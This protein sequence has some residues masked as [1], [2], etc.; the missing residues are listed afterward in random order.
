MTTGIHHI[1]AIAGDPQANVDFYA[2][3]LGLRVIKRT[4][5][6]DDPGTWHLY[7]G[8]EAGRPGTVLTFFPWGSRAAKGRPGSGQSTAV[9]FS[10]PPGSLDFWSRRLESRSP[11]LVDVGGERCVEIAD[12]DG[13]RVRLVGVAEDARPGWAE[14]GVPGQ[15]AVRGFHA[16]ELRL[17][18]AA[19]TEALMTGALGFRLVPGRAAG[20]GGP[21]RRRLQ[22][23]AGG[24]GTLVDLVE[25]AGEAAGR[26]GVGAI[27]HVAFRVGDD[28]RQI[29]LRGAL[30]R[31]GLAVSDVRDRQY[32]HSVYFVEP[33]GVLFEVATDGPGFAL[34][35]EPSRLG[36]ALKLPPWLEPEREK[37]EGAL[38]PVSFPA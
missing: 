21:A 23:G 34:D 17:R 38:A 29:A 1:T 3:V 9:A 10:V 4:V 20:G 16:V 13:I 33:G 22:A 18:S 6:F 5:N 25:D 2:G 8:D 36:R 11:R 32:F 7:Y 12:P 24:P 27:H 19:A 28:A 26:M 35:E 14:A 37:I 30:L 31:R 15:H